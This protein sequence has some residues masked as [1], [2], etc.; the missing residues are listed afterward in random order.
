MQGVETAEGDH[1]VIHMDLYPGNVM[2]Q[3]PQ[4]EEIIV[5]V[6]LIDV[7]AAMFIGRLVPPVAKY[8]LQRNGQLGIY[9]PSVFAAD[10]VGRCAM[11]GG[12]ML[13]LKLMPHSTLLVRMLHCLNR[14]R[15]NTAIR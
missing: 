13:C 9:H 8:I 14:G 3:C 5:E 15:W 7:D 11:T 4:D 2:P 10:A 1:L 6:K 12:Y